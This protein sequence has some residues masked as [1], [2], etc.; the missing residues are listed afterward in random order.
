MNEEWIEEYMKLLAKHEGTKPAKATEGGGYTRG[1]GITTL[2]D[3]FITSLA[4]NRGATADE[5]SDKELAR[6]YVIWN[7]QQIEKKF[8]NYNEWPSSVKMT[9]VDI[10]YNGGNVSKYKGFSSALSA[11]NYEEA[12]KQTLDIVSANDPKTSQGGVLRGLANRRVDFY[13]MVAN[14]VGFSAIKDFEIAPSSASG[15][16]THI[17]YNRGDSVIGFDFKSPLHSASGSYDT[18]VKKKTKPVATPVDVP[19]CL[20]TR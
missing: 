5:L 13:N 4:K 2:A 17:S 10:A 9:A 12:A 11:G 7:A 1:Y 6:E 19:Y 16:Q 18:D 15:K 8:P 14:E 20:S 3:N